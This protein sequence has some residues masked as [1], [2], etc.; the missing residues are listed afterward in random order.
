MRAFFS[1][2]SM[3]IT[4]RVVPQKTMDSQMQKITKKLIKG[5]VGPRGVMTRAFRKEI[6]KYSADENPI[7]KEEAENILVNMVKLAVVERNKLEGIIVDRV[8]RGLL[9]S[10]Y[11]RDVEKI[12]EMAIKTDEY[13]RKTEM[14]RENYLVEYGFYARNRMES[15]RGGKES[16][17]SDDDL[18]ELRKRIEKVNQ[19]TGFGGEER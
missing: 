2:L 4:R 17:L 15:Q 1:K 7:G 11:Y 13:Y 9:Y 6:K 18:E 16:P 12:S 3:G 10:E 5:S 8:E 19:Y 14:I